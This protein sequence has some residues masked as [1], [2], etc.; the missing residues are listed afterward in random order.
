[1]AESPTSV[2]DTGSSGLRAYSDPVIFRDDRV[3]KTLLRK[4]SKYLP[5]ARLS[6][7]D[8]ST[9]TSPM[10][11]GSGPI[12]IKPHMRKE[13]ADWMLEVCEVEKCHPEVVLLRIFV[14]QTSYPR[15]ARSCF[16]KKCLEL[17]L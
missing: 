9:N 17:D 12:N 8:T 2:K 4:E 14:I 1:M 5:S 6:L 15:V 16:I 3:L 10:S 7:A 13:V 11:I